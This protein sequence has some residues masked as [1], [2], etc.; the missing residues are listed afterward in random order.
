MQQIVVNTY[1]DWKGLNMYNKWWDTHDTATMTNVEDICPDLHVYD[2]LTNPTPSVT[3]SNDPGVDGSR[4]EY[5][6]LTKTQMQ[7]KAFFTF[8]DLADYWEKKNAIQ[9]YFVAK[10]GFILQTNLHPARHAVGYVTK[11]DIKP[12]SNHVADFSVMMDNAFGMW[13]TNSTSWLENNWESYLNRDLEVPTAFK[14]PPSWWLSAGDNRIWF[15][16]RQMSQLTNPIMDCKISIYGVGGD[17]FKLIN[18]STNTM[19]EYHGGDGGDMIMYNLDLRNSDGDPVN[20]Y[21]SSTDLWFNPGYNDI[22]LQG[23]ASGYI[24]TRFYFTAP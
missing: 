20:Q 16:G 6:N 5:S 15:A 2:F 10:A 1:R 9:S 11:C 17:G 12:S 24:D 19:Y 3:Y 21:T 23:A 22:E 8:T 18:H 4:F 7:I 14:Q 13:F